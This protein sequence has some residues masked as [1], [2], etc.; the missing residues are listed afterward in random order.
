MTALSAD[1]VRHIA[2]LARLELSDAEVA[3]LTG[4][5]G[6]IL[7]YVDQ[8][9]E[10]PTDGVEPTAQVTGTASVLRADELR[11]A[12]LA[13]AEELLATSPLP[14]RDRQIET[15]SAHG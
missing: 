1:Q 9:R 2:A 6:A 5:L 7:G 4:E 3:R 15:P 13:A 14:I 11:D 12:P 8:L 10:V